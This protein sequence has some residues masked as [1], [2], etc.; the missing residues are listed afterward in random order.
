M[1]R[2]YRKEVTLA[3]EQSPDNGKRF[4]PVM[5]SRRLTPL[6]SPGATPRE[7][8]E[9]ASKCHRDARSKVR[10]TRFPTPAAFLRGSSTTTRQC[11]IN[12]SNRRPHS[13]NVV[14]NSLGGEK[15]SRCRKIV[16]AHRVLFLSR[17]T[18]CKSNCRSLYF[19]HK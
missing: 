15:I 13:R 6:L 11:S 5:R 18:T 10:T 9:P 8:N 17:L 16:R 14:V 19:Y 12:F 7:T 3:C 1:G 2:A 4:S